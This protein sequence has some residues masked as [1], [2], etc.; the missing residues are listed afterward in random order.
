MIIKYNKTDT[1]PS[2]SIY[3]DVVWWPATA[4][5]HDTSWNSMIQWH[6]NWIQSATYASLMT[7]QRGQ[8]CWWSHSAKSANQPSPNLWIGYLKMTEPPRGIIVFTIRLPWTGSIPQFQTL[9]NGPKIRLIDGFTR[10]VDGS[11]KKWITSISPLRP[12]TY[13]FIW[14]WYSLPSGKLT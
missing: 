2:I 4:S 6:M 9:P 5:I 12:L 8:R 3:H 10:F 13:G 1:I 11:L 14:I 7:K